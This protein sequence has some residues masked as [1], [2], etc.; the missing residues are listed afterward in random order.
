[1]RVRVEPSLP[2]EDEAVSGRF[3]DDGTGRR[4]SRTS[5]SSVDALRESKDVERSTPL[6]PDLL[7]DSLVGTQQIRTGRLQRR[8]R[9]P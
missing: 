2:R 1:V 5:H 7:E 4:L 9:R 8:W 3:S 6:I